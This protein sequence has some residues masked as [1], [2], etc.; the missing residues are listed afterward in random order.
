M[1]IIVAVSKIIV[2]TLGA[3]FAWVLLLLTLIQIGSYRL[4]KSG[5]LPPGAMATDLVGI[6][7]SSSYSPWFW[8]T[9][10]G[11]VIPAVWLGYRWVRN[12]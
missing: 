4:Q 11:I 3:T 6:L 8:L 1:T 7:G 9:V 10:A 12:T 5:R 2:V